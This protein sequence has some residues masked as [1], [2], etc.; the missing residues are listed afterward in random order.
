MGTKYGFKSAIHKELE[1]VETARM[2]FK[3]KAYLPE[4]GYKA[5][6]FDKIPDKVNVGLE[7]AFTKAFELVFKH[8]IGIIEKGYDKKSIAAE[9]GIRNRE[10]ENNRSHKD[11]KKLKHSAQ[12]ADLL[13][14]T[15]TAAE[16]I[17]LGAVGVGI[18]DIVIFTG[19]L[20]KGIYEIALRYGYDYESAK[21]K[22]FILT[23]MRCAL[24]KGGEWE[25]LDREID[26]MMREDYS[27]GVVA[28]KTAIEDTSK[29]FA[30]DMLVM[31]FIQG[32]PVVG[33][34]GGAFNPIYYNK[35][36]KYAGNKYYKRYLIDK[37]KAI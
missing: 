14:M 6:L 17:G 13:N 4:S 37:L 28:L 22:Y 2:R 32:L 25:R 35:I 5:K 21:E 3:R 27:I 29:A 19:M 20:L 30:T 24:S 36:M 15:I 33:V 18:P 11:I 9:Y 34:L 31:K 10:I 8:G 26:T 7:S 16:G 23:I 12:R 1:A